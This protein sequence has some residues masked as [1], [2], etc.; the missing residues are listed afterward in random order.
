[1]SRKEVMTGKDFLSQFWSQ[2][3]SEVWAQFTDATEMHK[4]IYMRQLMGKYDIAG[5]PDWWD[6]DYTMR[7]LFEAGYFCITDTSMGVL[8]LNC[9]LAGI[10]VWNR[11]TTAVIANHI[12]GSFER[13]IDEDC[14]IVRLQ[15]NFQGVGRMRDIYSSLLACADG[16]I[17]TNLMNT[18]VTF[19][20]EAD[21]PASKKSWEKMY[22]EVSAGKPCVVVRKGM[23]PSQ[24]YYLNPKNS[25]IADMIIDAKKEIEADKLRKIGIQ[26]TVDKKQRVQSAE[27]DNANAECKFNSEHWIRTV[28]RELDKANKMFGLNL[29][30]EVKEVIEDGKEG[31]DAADVDGVEP[32]DSG[33]DSGSDGDE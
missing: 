23:N 7:L 18:R 21:D 24:F 11:P 6:H 20:A 28:R 5:M 33:R 14:V 16:S 30:F 25:Y 10:N 22:D 32:G 3:P 2:E 29:S 12:L 26:D 8:P 27:V 17:A 13:T 4:D 19:V 31:I 9:G 1:M 15:Y